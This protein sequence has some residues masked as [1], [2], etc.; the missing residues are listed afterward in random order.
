M[1]ESYNADHS[2]AP[3]RPKQ[4]PRT[5]RESQQARHANPNIGV[6]PLVRRSLTFWDLYRDTARPITLTGTRFW[7][8]THRTD[9]MLGEP[10]TLKCSSC[11]QEKLC[12]EFVFLRR[13]SQWCEP[14][15]F[16]NSGTGS[17]RYPETVTIENGLL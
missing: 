12:A 2:I 9:I 3:P 6:N 4:P 7:A 13:I 11:G 8:R 16:A 10:L 17:L 5:A 1:G 14:C 15:R